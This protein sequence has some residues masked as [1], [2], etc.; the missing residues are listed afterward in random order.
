MWQSSMEVM[1]INTLFWKNKKFNKE[2][3]IIEVRIGPAICGDNPKS[4]TKEVKNW[5]QSNFDAI[6]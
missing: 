1:V 6:H 3:G 5:I 4:I 2:P